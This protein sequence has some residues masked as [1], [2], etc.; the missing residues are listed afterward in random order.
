MATAVKWWRS[1]RP[2]APFLLIDEI[3]AA[4]DLVAQEPA[5]GRRVVVPGHRNVRRLLLRATGYHLYYQVDVHAAV[6]RLLAF[7]HARRRPIG[8]R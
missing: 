4:L 1:H 7:R 3:G 2:A 5:A 6:V 8:V